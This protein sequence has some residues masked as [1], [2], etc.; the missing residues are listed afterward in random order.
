MS[1]Y[2]II[3]KTITTKDTF[4]QSLSRGNGFC[5]AEGKEIIN[6]Q[7]RVVIQDIKRKQF[8]DDFSSDTH[9]TGLF[10]HSNYH[11]AVLPNTLDTLINN[12]DI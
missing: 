3:C 7:R 6:D 9:N 8:Y 4:L 12:N 10:T 11:H 5:L 2:L 1:I